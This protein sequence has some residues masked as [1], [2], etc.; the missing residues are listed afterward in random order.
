MIFQMV[1]R[2]E[3]AMFLFCIRS[4]MSESIMILTQA[5][6]FQYSSSVKNA[7]HLIPELQA[8]KVHAKKLKAQI[9]KD[10]NCDK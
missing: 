1:T 7:V 6:H 2:K 3:N 4:I 10:L 5:R 8:I 9:A